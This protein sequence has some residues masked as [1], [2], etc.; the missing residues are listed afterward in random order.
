MDYLEV[1]EKALSKE[2]EAVQLY[3]NFA[4]QHSA[5]RELFE[6]LANEE[7]KHV[8]LLEKKIAQLEL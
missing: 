3:K 8:S 6:F 4:I 1:L 2:R 7:E 5:L